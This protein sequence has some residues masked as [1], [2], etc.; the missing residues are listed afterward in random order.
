MS[1][2]GLQLSGCRWPL[3]IPI[4]IHVRHSIHGFSWA[5]GSRMTPKICGKTLAAQL[6]QNK[7]QRLTMLKIKNKIEI[8]KKYNHKAGHT[9]EM[10]SPTLT[11]SSSS[12][13]LS[14]WKHWGLISRKL[15]GLGLESL[16]ARI[17]RTRQCLQGFVRCQ[18]EKEPT[19]KKQRSSNIYHVLLY[20]CLSCN[21]H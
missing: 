6:V 3:R 7:L 12:G 5:K 17:A 9:K 20:V 15:V 18:G 19:R 1:P 2:H 8:F 14:P 11:L 21:A 4:D 13:A 10:A 16:W